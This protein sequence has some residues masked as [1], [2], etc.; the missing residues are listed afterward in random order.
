MNSNSIMFSLFF[1]GMLSLQS[2]SQVKV[3]DNPTT[4]NS[5]AALEV[6]STAKGLLPPRMTTA[7][8]DAIVQPATGLMIYNTTLSCLQINDG[9]PAVPKWNCISNGAGIPDGLVTS[10]NCAGAVPSGTLISGQEALELQ[11]NFHMREEME[12]CMVCKPSMLLE[13]RV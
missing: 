2:F 13:F 3:G 9:T 4:I 6:E 11:F 12:G 8:R 5:S 7:Q 10:L 1:I